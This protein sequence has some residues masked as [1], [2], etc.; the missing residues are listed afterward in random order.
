MLE[1]TLT[2]GFARG[3]CGRVG[4][5]RPAACAT[6]MPSS[7]RAPIV[8]ALRPNLLQRLMRRVGLR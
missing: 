7:Y 5:H 1:P 6:G 8:I 4:R 3:L 2:Q